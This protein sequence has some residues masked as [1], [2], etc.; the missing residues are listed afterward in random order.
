M[1]LLVTGASGFIGSNLIYFLLRQGHEISIVTRQLSRIK[2]FE[3]SSNVKIYEK[4]LLSLKKNDYEQFS[5]NDVVIHL[6]W[7]GLPNYH[8][9]IHNENYFISNEFIKTL[10]DSGVKN[11]LITGTCF[12]YGM[13]NG[14]LTEDTRTSPKNNYGIAKE[15]LRN[16]ILGYSEKKDVCIQ[17]ARLFYLYGKGQNQNSLIGQLEQK[18]KNNEKYFH[19]SKGDQLRDYLSIEDVCSRISK[20]IE[21]NHINGVI[22]ICSNKPI[23]I[24]NLVLKYIK[25]KNKQIELIKGY[26]NYNDY[27]P[28]NFWGHSK[29]FD[30]IGNLNEQ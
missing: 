13:Q 20:L 15:K 27:E 1:K 25:L 9:N 26:Y 19:M 16:S 2:E 3:W 12:E 21:N 24:E 28:M 30:S 7:D 17:W 4:D 6:A 8:D 22:N 10:I 23:S 29:Y 11:F 5:K 18:L 14:C